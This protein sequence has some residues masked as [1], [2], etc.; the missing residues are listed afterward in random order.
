M[1]V[2]KRQLQAN[3]IT[4]A[5]VVL[6]EVENQTTLQHVET[7]RQEYVQ[8][9]MDLC[10]QIGVPRLA[11]TV[12][13]VGKLQWPDYRE[14]GD[15]DGFVRTALSSRPEILAAQAQA[16]GSHDAVSLARA[17][18]TGRFTKKTNPTPASMAWG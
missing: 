16:A 3:Q 18:R 17:D 6:A 12:E 14:S 9:Q 2:L 13:L 1:E 11:D 15:D 7:A 5:D 8:A 10:Q 4:A